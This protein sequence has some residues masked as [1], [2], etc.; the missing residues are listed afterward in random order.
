MKQKHFA[1][2]KLYVDGVGL[3]FTEICLLYL[4]S[5]SFFWN[6]FIHG[7]GKGGIHSQKCVIRQFNYDGVDIEY[8]YQLR[9]YGTIGDVLFLCGPLLTE[10]SLC[11]MT[12]YRKRYFGDDIQV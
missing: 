4:V 3:K 7:Y 6:I 5:T 2:F 9:S 10:T 12:L 11:G 1:S 8:F